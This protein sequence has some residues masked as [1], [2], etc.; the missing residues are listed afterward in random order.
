MD[1]KVLERY[2]RQLRVEGW[3]Q[4][5]L[6][7]ATVMIV[8]VG[9]IGCEV[10][11]NLALMGVGRLILVDNDVVEVSNL[12]RQMLFADE[13]IGR[14]KAETAAEKLRKM[15][16]FVRVE[17]HY[18]DVRE[19]K[20]RLFEESHVVCSCLDNWP[21][22]R[23]VNSM[24]VE[25]GKPLVDAAIEGM[26]ANLQVVI[27]GKT[28]CLECHGEDLVPRD[29]QLAECTLRR[30]RP[31]D[32]VRDLE[33]QGVE[34]GRELA[35][36]LFALGIKTV[37]DLKYSQAQFLEKLDE[38]VREKVKEIQEMLKP[39]MPALQSVS[40]TISGLASTEAIKLLH[41]GALGKPLKGLLVYDGYASKFTRLRLDRRE[42]CFVCGDY[43]REKGAELEV[44]LDEKIIDIKKRIAER[45]GF[46]D[47]ELLYKKWK[48]RDGQTLGQ[49]EAKEGDIIYVETSRRFTPLPLMLKIKT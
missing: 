21:V 10:A 38:E 25:L 36:K 41:D 14:P 5:K 26:Y 18:T 28:S 31:E 11:K 23:W 6:S 47:P 43:V 35:K 2:E 4:D 17:A 45:F 16:P 39:R 49:L 8:G 12:S 32:L 33:E 34:V 48:L 37:F 46:P 15:N 3:R 22:R 19:L 20:T 30:R 42:D 44:K 7:S 29:V 13:D 40:A 24:A 9:A 27:P 1:K